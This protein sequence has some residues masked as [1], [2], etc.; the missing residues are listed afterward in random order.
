M[1]NISTFD[2]WSATAASNQ[3]DSTDSATIQADLQAI[4]A[5]MRKNLGTKGADIASAA[6]TDLST[7][8][9]YFVDVTGTTT[10]TAFGTLAAGLWK[11]V[12]FSGALTL[13]HNNTSLIL[14]GDSNIVTVGGDCLLAISLGA[15]NWKVPFYQKKNGHPIKV[16]IARMT[17]SFA[18]G[19]LAFNTRGIVPTGTCAAPIDPDGIVNTTTQKITPTKAG[20]Y[21]IFTSVAGGD[22]GMNFIEADVYKNGSYTSAGLNVS[23]NS[24]VTY[25]TANG[26]TWI[27]MNGTTDYLEIGWR[28]TN[29]AGTSMDITNALVSMQIKF[30]TP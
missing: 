12:R 4:Q 8:T 17:V 30:I 10:I 14:P 25:L 20:Y 26:E 1:A 24:D 3:P 28:A 21:S 22:G 2:T 7:A 29:T 5:E 11:I 9:G 13:T 16:A 23:G 6:T 27:S 19:T 15:G 18:S